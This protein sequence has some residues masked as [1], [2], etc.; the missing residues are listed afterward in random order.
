MT[1]LRSKFFLFFAAIVLSVPCFSQIIAEGKTKI[2]RN[3]PDDPHL[4]IFESK[5]VITAF[6]TKR[7]NF[8]GKAAL[9]N[10]T[11]CHVF[12]LLSE[13]GVP[14][15]FRKQLD[16]RS[17]L[18]DLCEMIQ[19]E[20]VVRREAH[21]SYLKRHPELEKGAVFPKL[22][23]EFFLKT[24]DNNWLGTAI[25]KDDPFIQFTDSGAELYLPDV[26][27]TSQKPFLVLSDYPLKDQPQYFEQ[28]AK[29]AKQTFLILEKAWQMES[30][31]LVDFKVEF[32]FNYKGELL[33]ADV[34]D[35]DSWRVIQNQQYIDK[36]A[37]RDGQSVDAVTLLY[38]R[39]CF[40]T[41]HFKLPDQ[42]L[43]LWR[44]SDKDDLDPFVKQL[45][46]FENTHLKST[47]VTSSVHKNP[48]GSNSVLQEKLKQVPDSVLISYNGTSNGAGPTLSASPTIPVITTPAGWD[49]RA[50]SATPVM[51]VMEPQNAL[52]A[53]L[54]ILACRNPLLYMQL[55][56]EQEEHLLNVVESD[57]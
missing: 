50:P 41:D 14:V 55:R 26:P 5:D 18:G 13:C 24:S 25:P 31:R 27:I 16:E 17:F 44:E 3:Y 7:E 37:Y 33:L 46:R 30:A 29:I 4:A 11:T 42:Q 54:Q 2:V 53:A 21:G 40:L 8:T 38:Q 6:N 9:A 32:G 22:V 35:N 57:E 51:T 36:Q 1:I 45:G 15:A 39:V 47:I 56:M 23:V 52:L 28:I 34:I 20:V 10:Q 43:I 19:Y 49:V 48:I 12:R